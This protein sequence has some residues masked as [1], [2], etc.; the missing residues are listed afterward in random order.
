MLILGVTEVVYVKL[1]MPIRHHGLMVV[2]P[3]I[4]IADRWMLAVG[5]KYLDIVYSNDRRQTPV[6]T[7]RI[8][9]C[10]TC[11]VNLFGIQQTVEN[12][13]ISLEDSAVLVQIGDDDLIRNILESHKV[14]GKMGAKILQTITVIVDEPT[15]LYLHRRWTFHHLACKWL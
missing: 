15:I 3:T 4:T 12:G 13:F 14:F 9:Q 8:A 1:I 10:L 7:I 11:I 5:T 2:G 6:V